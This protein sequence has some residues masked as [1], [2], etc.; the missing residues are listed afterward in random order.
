MTADEV[1]KKNWVEV[2]AG[3]S[4]DSELLPHKV[5]YLYLILKIIMK[6]TIFNSGINIVFVIR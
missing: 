4:R 1:D 5:I 6:Y 2:V 3:N